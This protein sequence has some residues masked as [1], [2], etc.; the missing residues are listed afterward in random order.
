VYPDLVSTDFDADVE[1]L[2]GPG[3]TRPTAIR[4]GFCPV[5]HVRRSRGQR[6]R[7]DRG[8][9]EQPAT[10]S[11]AR[12][13]CS[14]C[15]NAT[16]C[17]IAEQIATPAAP[18]P[19]PA[20][21]LRRSRVDRARL[22]I[23]APGLPRAA[24]SGTFDTDPGAPRPGPRRRPIPAATGTPAG[25][26]LGAH[27][28]LRRREE[29]DRSDDRPIGQRHRRHRRRGPGRRRGRPLAGRRTA[30]R[31]AGRFPRSVRA[32]RRPSVPIK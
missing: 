7:P 8:L 18:F 12:P 21:A 3:A 31:H 20:H 4:K 14:S 1:R 22:H 28:G 13:G 6:V 25:H 27:Q 24:P 23:P 11:G 32:A 30:D 19:W 17:C 10:P 16:R 15:P 5:D 9:T 29:V 26:H 2:L